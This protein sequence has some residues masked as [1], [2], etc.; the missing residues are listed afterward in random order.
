M[1]GMVGCSDWFG[2]D[3]DTDG[4]FNMIVVIKGRGGVVLGKAGSNLP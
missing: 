4:G 1:D 3:D 2:V